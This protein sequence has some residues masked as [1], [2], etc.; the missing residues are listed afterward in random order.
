MRQVSASFTD[1]QAKTIFGEAANNFEPNI[2]EVLAGLI[3]KKAG[4][5]ALNATSIIESDLQS[6]KIATDALAKEFVAKAPVC[7]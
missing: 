4:I 5:S 2:K 3:D 6:L 1:A 7:R